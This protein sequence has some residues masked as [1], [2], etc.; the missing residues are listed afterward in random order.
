MVLEKTVGAAV[1]TSE[2]IAAYQA[3]LEANQLGV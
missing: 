1:H 3:Q 2:C